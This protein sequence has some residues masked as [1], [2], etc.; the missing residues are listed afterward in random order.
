M[1]KILVTTQRGCLR[2][3]FK[4]KHECIEAITLLKWRM[5]ECTLAVVSG[6][7][8]SVLRECM[9]INLPAHISR[10]QTRHVN[11]NGGGFVSSRC[12]L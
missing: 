12:L 1:F 6:N 10:R 5:R 8:V 2:V 9:A 4:R 7:A 11:E 3:I